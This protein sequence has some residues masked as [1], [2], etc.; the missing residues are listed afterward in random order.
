MMVHGSFYFGNF[1]SQL[2]S[3]IMKLDDVVV[4]DFPTNQDNL[5]SEMIGG[6]YSNRKEVGTKQ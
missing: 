4:I 5:S 1:S 3:L 6:K 2:S